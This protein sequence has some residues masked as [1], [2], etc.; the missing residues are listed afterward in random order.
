M[1]KKIKIDDETY[2]LIKKLSK[3]KN[4][5]MNQLIIKLLEFGLL[6]EMKNNE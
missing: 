6:K 2:M 1:E 5:T 3:D 4:M